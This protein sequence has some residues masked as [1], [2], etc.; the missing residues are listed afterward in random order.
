MM[1]LKISKV[2]KKIDLLQKPLL[3]IMEG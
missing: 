2:K 1:I 3:L